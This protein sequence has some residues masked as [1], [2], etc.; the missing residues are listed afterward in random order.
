MLNSCRQI[1]SLATAYFDF[2]LLQVRKAENSALQQLLVQMAISEYGG[3]TKMAAGVCGDI[4]KFPI[5]DRI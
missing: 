5:C 2:E 4:R 1:L 3:G